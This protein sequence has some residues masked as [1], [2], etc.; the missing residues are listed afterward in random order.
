MTINEQKCF[1]KFLSESE[2]YETYFPLF[3]ILS[4][5]GMRIGEVADLIWQDINLEEQYLTV[6]RSVR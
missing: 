1:L 4:G 3:T 6:R 2:R 5:I